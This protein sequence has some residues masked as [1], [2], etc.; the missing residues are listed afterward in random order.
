MVTKQLVKETLA[1]LGLKPDDAVI[2]HSSLKSFGIVDGGADT[3]IDAFIEYLSEGTVLF[4]ALRTKNFKDAYKDWNINTT[5]S[6]VG[7]ISETFRLRDGVL[8]SDQATHSVCA[9]GRDALFYTCAHGSGILR[10]GPFGETAFDTLSPWQKMYE[11]GAKIVM[12]GV[13]LKYSTMKHLA[14]SILMND[15]LD[16]LSGEELKEA[17][18]SLATYDD[19]VSAIEGTGWRGKAWPWYDG[20]KLQAFLDEK[21]LISHAK[22]GECN[23]ISIDA[24]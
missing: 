7:F 13:S 12:L 23:I 8:R 18:D 1:G 17:V 6:D 16:G 15:I 2:I 10:K 14:E 20:D 5:P 19:H 4:P 24:I 3:I 9:Y 21:G 11:K 22:C